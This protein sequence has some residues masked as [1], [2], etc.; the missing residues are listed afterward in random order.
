MPLGVEVYHSRYLF[1]EF[2]PCLAPSKDRCTKLYQAL[3]GLAHK[4]E[5]GP[6]LQIFSGMVRCVRSV[7]DHDR[8]CIPP[9]L[10]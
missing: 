6:I 5:V 3:F 4:N 10:G 2:A 9:R 8:P 7:S 1:G